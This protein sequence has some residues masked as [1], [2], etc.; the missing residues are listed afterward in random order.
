MLQRASDEVVRCSDRVTPFRG[1][2]EPDQSMGFSESIEIETSSNTHGG[3]CER[4]LIIG[5]IRFQPPEN[6]GPE[7][8]AQLCGF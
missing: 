3:I 4:E 1:R 8:Q 6:L 5:S 2:D 7:R